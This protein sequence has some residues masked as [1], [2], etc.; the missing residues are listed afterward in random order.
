VFPGE[1][2][3]VPLLVHSASGEVKLDTKALKRD[4]EA[5][6]KAEQATSDAEF[7]AKLHKR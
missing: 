7:E 1:G 3:K 4:R 6:R 2:A 5:A